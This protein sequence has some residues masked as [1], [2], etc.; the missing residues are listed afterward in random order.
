[1]KHLLCCTVGAFNPTRSHL[2]KGAHKHEE[3]MDVKKEERKKK[4][5]VIRRSFVVCSSS[6]IVSRV[7]HPLRCT[8]GVFTPSWSSLGTGA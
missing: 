7:K 3:E 8:V 2:G 6:S 5:V 4:R 1:M